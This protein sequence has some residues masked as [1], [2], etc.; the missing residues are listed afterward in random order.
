MSCRHLGVVFALTAL[1]FVTSSARAEDLILTGRRTDLAKF[2]ATKT[3][4]YAAEP[5]F[6]SGEQATLVRLGNADMAATL[7]VHPGNAS[8]E[9][10]RNAKSLRI[11]VESDR[12]VKVKSAGRDPLLNELWGISNNGDVRKFYLDN[13]SS[14]SVKGAKGE[15][16]NLPPYS[17]EGKGMVVAI[18]D[19]GFD[20]SHPDL[21]GQFVTKPAECANLVKYQACLDKAKSTNSLPTACDAEFMD[22][23]KAGNDTDGNLYPMDCHGWNFVGVKNKKSGQY[24]TPDIAEQFECGTGHGTKVAGVVGALS[25]NAIGVRGIAPGVK[26]LGVRVISEDAN[27]CG[28]GGVA[29]PSQASSLISTVVHGM[30]YA[31]AEKVNVINLSLGWNGRADSPLMRDAVKIA[32]SKG[33]IVVAAAGNDST[34]AL[35]YPCQYEG[36]VCVGSHDPNGAI[37]DFS[38]F[39]SGVDIAAP[40]FSILSTIDQSAD[41]IYFTDRQGYD[42]DSGT[43]FASPYVAGA[44][45]ILRS[46]GYSVSETIARLLVG[47]RPKPY[48]EGKVVLT[49][50]LDV[51]RAMKAAPRPFFTPENKGVY[52][53]IWDRETN[54]AALGIDLKNIWTTAKK[55]RVHLSLSDRDQSLGQIRILKPDFSISNWGSGAI[56][57]LEAP[58][59]ILDPKVTSDATLVLEISADGFPSQKMRIP[60]LMSVVLEKET[61]LPNAKTIPIIGSVDKDADIL[62][63]QS[64]DGRPEQDYVAIVQGNDVWKYQI[65]REVRSNAG[66]TYIAGQVRS[67]PALANA[68]PRTA[69]RLDVNLDG[70]PDYVFSTLVLSEE[71]DHIPYFRF[72]YRDAD[73]NDVLPSYL[74]K[75]RTS[76][77]Q[78]DRFQWIRSGN[79]LV[80]AWNGVGLTPKAEHLPY[81]PWHPNVYVNEETDARLYYHDPSTE[82]GVRSIALPKDP[83]LPAHV[84]YLSLLNQS[85]SDV[86]AGKISTLITE[87]GDYVSKTFVI[88]FTSTDAPG[89][90]FP[91]ETPQYRN[92][93][94]VEAVR[95]YPLSSSPI[96]VATTFAST[97]AISAERVSGIAK[98]GDGYIMLD[99]SVTPESSYD[100][101]YKTMAAFSEGPANAPT[102]LS[103]FIQAS[104]D[105][106]YRDSTTSRNLSTS[107]RRYTFLASSL[108]ERTFYPAVAE[109][110]GERVGALQIPDTFGA[111]PGAEIIVPLKR[112]GVSIDLIRPAAL[113]IQLPNPD[114][115][116]NHLPECDWLSRMDPTAENPSQAVYFC[117]DR[118][119]RLPYRY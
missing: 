76:V 42:F 103:A 47:A 68:A 21:A 36:V 15:D 37:S 24:G 97:S 61:K 52:P 19:S 53:L 56:Q 29:K 58:I 39:G 106:I 62:T 12:K 17:N 108:F 119:I 86:T 91:L 81:D 112:N 79:R 57:S 84:T 7:L 100:T 32:Q 26:I 71:E 98:N 83:I 113:R 20:V 118:F 82:D 63:I 96:A 13:F 66:S 30:I 23:K 105:V 43:S 45:A 75:N 78:L 4:R 11:K 102:G 6:T 25:N 33:I 18:L 99:R 67:I 38:N 74:F 1:A 80:Q 110:G 55:V 40:G 70:K 60:L 77:L 72:D 92:L 117:G 107:L 93:R 5:L 59:A 64:A 94:S 41:P 3:K 16:V 54:T 73:G 109:T 35:V 44:V 46:Q 114:S 8:S 111:Y 89:K 88:E 10:M 49:G 51:S 116:P 27:P 34:D 28:E 115:L 104:Y 22:V 69:Q 9:I 101:A 85:R 48:S 31:T 87:D 65:I 95:A 14:I 50:N 90:V 2:R